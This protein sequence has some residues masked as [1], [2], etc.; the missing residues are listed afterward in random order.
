MPGAGLPRHARDFHLMR[1]SKGCCRDTGDP[2]WPNRA[3]TCWAM[4]TRPGV[5]DGRSLLK[6]AFTSDKPGPSH[7]EKCHFLLT[8]AQ[9]LILHPRVNLSVVGCFI[10]EHLPLGEKYKKKKTPLHHCPDMLGS[11]DLLVW[12]HPRVQVIQSRHLAKTDNTSNRYLL[13]LL[14][15]WPNHECVARRPTIGDTLLH[16]R[17][18]QRQRA[19]PTRPLSSAATRRR[20]HRL[21]PGRGATEP[22]PNLVIAPSFVRR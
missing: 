14:A 11:Q 1:C 10:L 20:Y 16:R 22:S 6:I 3:W 2:C 9:S 5:L 13:V 4:D 21:G 18:S 17:A 12:H 19:T 8:V 15:L 7:P